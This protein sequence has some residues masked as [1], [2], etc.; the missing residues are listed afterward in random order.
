VGVVAGVRY[1][2]RRY[3]S[4]SDQRLDQRISPHVRASYDVS[5]TVGLFASY[6]FVRNRSQAFYNYSRH[7]GGAGVEV[8]W[9]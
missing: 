6:A 5:D 8:R 2:Y 9:P 7:L 4:S 1:A 3:A